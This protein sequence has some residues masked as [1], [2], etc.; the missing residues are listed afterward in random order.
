[1]IGRLPVAAA[2]EELDRETLLRILTEPKNALT[3]QYHVLF[4]MEG[5]ELV[6][7]PSALEEVVDRAVK[8]RTGARGLR[9]FL[10]VALLDTMYEIPSLPGL[11]KVTVTG[12]VIRD[13]AKPILEFEDAKKKSA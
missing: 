6:I 12:D 2:M 4:A 13:R 1:L 9:S 8:R 3:R 5:I 10:E 7:E 11:K